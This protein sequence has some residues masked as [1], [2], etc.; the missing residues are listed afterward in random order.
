MVS[1]WAMTSN[2]IVT[3]TTLYVKKACNKLYS[4]RVLRRAGVSKASILKVYLT[5]IRPVL[6]YAVPVWQFISDCLADVMESVQKRA[7]KIVFLVEES[8]TGKPWVKQTCQPCKREEKICA[9]NI[10]KRWNLETIL[11]IYKFLPRPVVG[12]CNYKLRKNSEKFLLFNNSITCR[13]K[14]ADSFF[15]I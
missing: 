10:W 2:G 13:T 7:L 11:S 9:V 6:E 5:T 12:T 4:L 1:F 14:R 3:L 15:Y 8:Y